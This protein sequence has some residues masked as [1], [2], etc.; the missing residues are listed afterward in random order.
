MRDYLEQ[1]Q[2]AIGYNLYY[3]AFMATLAVPDL[4]GALDSEDGQAT[5]EK[6]IDWYDRYVT[7]CDYLDGSTCYYL[8]CSMLHQGSTQHP[9]SRYS[10]VIFI[11]PSSRNIVLHCNILNDALNIDLRV[12][13]ND[14]IGAAARWLAEV[15]EMERFKA[16]Y[17]RFIHRYPDGLRPY[18]VGVPVIG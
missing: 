13:C 5:K 2:L 18:I 3:V 16:N 11:E 15:E 9:S 7:G 12:F 10:K 1:I 17:S 8:R 6:Y 14:V 4:C